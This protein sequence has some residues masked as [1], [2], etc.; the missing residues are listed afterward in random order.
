[1]AKTGGDILI[2]TIQSWGVDVIFGFPGRRHQRD[3]GI[4]AD[5][6]GQHSIHPS[7]A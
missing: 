1:M 2:E 6:A 5:T 4:A 7:A 3:H